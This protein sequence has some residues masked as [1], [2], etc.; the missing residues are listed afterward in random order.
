MAQEKYAQYEQLSPFELKDKLLQMA[1]SRHE[2]MMLN[3]GRGNPN[4]VATTPRYG[5]FQ[6]GLFAMGE[7]ERSFPDLAHF[8]GCPRRDGIGARF[9]AF[10][11]AN[12]EKAGVDFLKKAVSFARDELGIAVSDFLLELTDG[13]LGDHYPVP[14]RMLKHCE[15]VAAAYVR[16][17]LAAGTTFEREFDLFATEGGT[18]AMT[19]VFQTLRENK[20]LEKGDTIA[21][22][23][24]IFT[25]Y[26]EI[27]ELNDYRLVEVE[28]VADEKLE[29]QIPDSEIDKLLDP[30]IKA[31][32]LTNPSNP[33]S[34]KLK[35]STIERI[36]RIV[37]SQR[38]DL[39]ILTDD[40]YCTFTN[41]FVSLFAAAP[42][43]TIGVYSWS[44]YFGATGWRLGVIAL[45]KDNALDRMITELPRGDRD[46]LAERYASISL[47]PQG[48]KLIDRMVADSRTVA[49]NHTAG[50]STPQQVQMALFCLFCLMDK[51]EGYKKDAQGIVARRH[52]DLYDALGI[53]MPANPES[54][55]YYTE[56]EMR[57]IAEAAYGKE[58]ADWIEENINP[59]EFVFKLA[60][61][62]EVVL[63]PGGGFHA[64]KSSVR[65]SLAN[66]DRKDYTAIG[67]RT[68]TLVD[69]YYRKW[70]ASQG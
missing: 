24:P 29:W 54:A 8:G 69:E 25:P 44:K 10:V 58:L 63:M 30:R 48:I 61:E 46:E 62:E 23:S 59:L 51:Q 1:A 35:K 53:E 3:A 7:A 70:K 67:R 42:D 15:S 41:G 40:V 56:I 4:W 19:Y 20:L 18:A 14:D 43:N 31:F 12:I 49:L 34:V 37:E 57:T 33:P 2:K 5:F 68:R 32:F 38:K 21:I 52:A 65:V 47:D 64:P 39:I 50:L 13:I 66:L 17:E 27:P 6:L 28:I 36:V 11:Q 26:L 22:G 60:E 16:K 9:D 45:C 55:N